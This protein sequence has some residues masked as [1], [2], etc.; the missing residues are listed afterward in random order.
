M[1]RD[2]A[3]DDDTSRIAAFMLT[4]QDVDD[5]LLVGPLLDQIN[6][7]VAAF[8]ADSAVHRKDVHAE[9][10]ARQPDAEMIA[11]PWSGAVPSEAVEPAPTQ[12]VG[13]VVATGKLGRVR[14]WRASGDNWCALVEA[15]ISR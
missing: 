7:P 4:G 15:E 8:N 3:A 10:A 13:H 1:P 6:G 2:P 9:V 5:A 14:W 11:P 12:R